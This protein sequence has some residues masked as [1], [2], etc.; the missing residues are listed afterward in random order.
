PPGRLALFLPTSIVR[1]RR[2]TRREPG[3]DRDAPEG[4]SS[5]STR[6]RSHE[7]PNNCTRRR[8]GPP[9]FPSAR[10]IVRRGAREGLRV[11]RDG[12]GRKA[13]AAKPLWTIRG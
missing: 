13:F 6:P 2:L 5:C 12:P 10:R 4:P 7:P 3:T 1:G 9:G 11:V 8:T